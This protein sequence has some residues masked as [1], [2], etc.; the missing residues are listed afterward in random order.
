MSCRAAYVDSGGGTLF[1]FVIGAVCG[2]AYDTVKTFAI[3]LFHVKY[4]SFYKIYVALLVCRKLIILCAKGADF[5]KMSLYAISDLH[6]SL[7]TDKPMSVFGGNWENYEQKLLKNWNEKVK[8]DDA[9][10]VNGD[11]SWATYLEN[12]HKDF[13]FLNNLNGI[14][15]VS[16]G[17]HDYW[18][19][20]MKKQRDFCEKMSFDTI[21]F[22][23]NN[24]FVYGGCAVCA[25][26]GWLLSS[27]NAE[28]KKIYNRELERLQLGLREAK[29]SGS[30]RI[31]AALHYPPDLNFMTVL[32]KFSVS[33]CV[34][35]HLHG[36]VCRNSN[37]FEGNVNGVEYKLVSCDF[38]NFDPV[39][40]VE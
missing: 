31:I 29:K 30:K 40:L 14:K 34:Y 39:R 21:N 25:T 6:L 32:E 28:D 38:L 8:P 36:D 33:I 20:T 37:Y 1:R 12:T 16:K 9:V 2:V 24:C 27:N 17:N 7:G 3:V 35:G 18:W 13:E 15:L 5:P 4:T 19:T 26:R 23:Q 22:L 11:V 10:I